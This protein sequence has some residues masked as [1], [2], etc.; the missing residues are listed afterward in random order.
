MYNVHV[1][2][3]CGVCIKSMVLYSTFDL[4]RIIFNF[5]QFSDEEYV[6]S[7]GVQFTNSYKC[8]QSKVQLISETCQQINNKSW[9]RIQLRC[10]L[11]CC[12]IWSGPI[13]RSNFQICFRVLK[14]C[15]KPIPMHIYG[16][17]CIELAE[18]TQTLKI[19]DFTM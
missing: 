4:F 7:L 18:I 16:I 2:T 11:R 10:S 5:S 9:Q 13:W 19:T 3:L 14:N 12:R 8:I 1:C 17:Q 15:Y 6:S